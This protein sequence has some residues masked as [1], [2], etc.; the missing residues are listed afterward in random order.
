VPRRDAIMI[1]DPT[2]KKQVLVAGSQHSCRWPYKAGGARAV[3]A[4]AGP[5]HAVNRPPRDSADAGA[6]AASLLVLAPS[7]R[8]SDVRP[9]ACPLPVGAYCADAAAQA[10]G[11]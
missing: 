1:T 6:Q 3:A 8:D 2:L 10:D 9:Q 11:P 4:P 5:G 7:G